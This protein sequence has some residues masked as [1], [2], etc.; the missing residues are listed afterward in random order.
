M[1]VSSHPF[2]AG[3]VGISRPANPRPVQPISP[4][5]LKLAGEALLLI[6]VTLVCIKVVVA[7]FRSRN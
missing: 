6:V 7:L 2:L 1:F 3:G 4:A 5:E